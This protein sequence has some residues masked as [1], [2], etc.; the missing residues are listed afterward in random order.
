LKYRCLSCH[1]ADEKARA[2]V[3]EQIYG[4]QVAL[5]S[6]QTVVADEDYLRES[7]LHPAA[8][9]VAGYESIMPT[10]E[11][12]ISDEELIQLIGFIKALGPGETPRRVEDYPPPVRITNPA[13]KNIPSGAEPNADR[14]NNR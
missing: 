2:P 12:L 13:E 8:K 5:R 14:E 3:L 4:K 6:G 11:G 10:Y 1:S 7:I 9:I